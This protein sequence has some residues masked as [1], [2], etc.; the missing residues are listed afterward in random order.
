MSINKKISRTFFRT[1]RLAFDLCVGISRLYRLYMSTIKWSV[2]NDTPQ[3]KDK[4][5]WQCV[6]WW[7]LQALA[8]G[9]GCI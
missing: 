3:I 5:I 1:L 9:P 2:K 4:V 6:V 8:F 7:P